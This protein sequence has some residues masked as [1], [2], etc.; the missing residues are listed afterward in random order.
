[1]FVIQFNVFPNGKKRIITFSY[2]DGRNDIKL[3]EL[4][5]KYN[6]KGTFHL[7]GKELSDDEK[8]II[9]KRY[10][11]HEISCHT[12]THGWPSRMPH[13]S[14]INE[15]LSNRKLLEQISLYPVVGMSY[16]SGSYD[17]KT[18]EAMRSCGIVYSRTTKDT[19]CFELPTD[20]MQWHPTCH[21]N[22]ALSLCNKFLN[23]ID[24]Q[25]CGPLFYIWG[26][27]H[28]FRT[29]EEWNLM[30]ALLEKI[31]NNDR[32]WYATNYE[33]WEYLSAQRSLVISA[34]ETIFYNPSSIDVWVEKDKME[35]IKISAGETVII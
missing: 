11:G 14:I 19:M 6:V 28:E 29:D 30:I 33:I 9:R 2:D 13:I 23:D 20:F 16:P 32:I 26:H 27:S 22:K 25:W 8:L 21:H 3:L 1:M 4:F 10:E 7:N 34:D 31:S 17:N 24:S 5:N 15:T 18:I 35:I 12:A